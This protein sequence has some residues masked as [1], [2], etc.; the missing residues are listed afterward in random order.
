MG[1][2]Q[3]ERVMGLLEGRAEAISGEFNSRQN[4]ANSGFR[5]C[6]FSTCVHKRPAPVILEWAITCDWT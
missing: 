6:G 2:K 3:E 1:R 4:V 5:T